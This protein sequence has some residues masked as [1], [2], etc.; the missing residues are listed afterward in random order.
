MTAITVDTSIEPEPNPIDLVEQIA[1][2]HDL[3]RKNL[4]AATADIHLRMEFQVMQLLRQSLRKGNV[5]GVHARNKFTP[6]VC[7]AVIK[8]AGNAGLLATE[9]AQSLVRGIQAGYCS[10]VAAVVHQQEI[11]LTE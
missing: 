11:Q 2:A 8:S 1:G 9:D 6:G 3:I 7:Q 10:I 5:I 4:H